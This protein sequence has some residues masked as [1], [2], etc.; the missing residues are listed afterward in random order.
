MFK[1]RFQRIKSNVSSLFRKEIKNKEQINQI[2]KALHRFANNKDLLVR[3]IF[4]LNFRD[5][6]F[7]FEYNV[8]I[9]KK[10]VSVIK[11]RKELGDEQKI[12]IDINNIINN[13]VR[14]GVKNDVVEKQLDIKPINHNGYYLYLKIEHTYL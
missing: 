12:K 14:D 6:I 9:E 13:A 4:V 5:S 1:T 11:P 10:N 7:G 3:S 8:S 2:Y